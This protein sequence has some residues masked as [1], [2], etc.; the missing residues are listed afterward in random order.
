MVLF[1]QNK[2]SG[3]HISQIHEAVLKNLIE[4]H[5]NNQM[6]FSF[7]KI[8]EDF[9]I[10]IHLQTIHDNVTTKKSIKKLYYSK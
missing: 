9:Y 8:H 2:Y 3:W 10:C 5:A 1:P 7:A 4:A 6:K